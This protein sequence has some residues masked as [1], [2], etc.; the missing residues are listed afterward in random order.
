MNTLSGNPPDGS[1]STRSKEHLVFR[2][3]TSSLCCW[4]AVSRHTVSGTL[5]LGVS[6]RAASAKLGSIARTTATVALP[7]CLCIVSRKYF[8]AHAVRKRHVPTSLVTL[9]CC[10]RRKTVAKVLT[11]AHES[12]F[13][14]KHFLSKTRTKNK[15]TKRRKKKKKNEQAT[16]SPAQTFPT[17]H[18]LT[19][20]PV[21]C[22]R[23]S[24]H[25][26]AT[27]VISGT[28][29]P[30]SPHHPLHCVAR[31]FFPTPH[32]LPR[33]RTIAYRERTRR[34]PDTIREYDGIGLSTRLPALAR[35]GFIRILL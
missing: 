2:M 25:D 1:V 15:T 6:L 4:L 14:S 8:A 28:T 31:R 27:I 33:H 22:S 23:H 13:D 11:R 19:P 7:K 3:C 29:S 5:P 30:T 26:F 35:W 20:S 21:P 10:R 12:A 18:S 34:Q 9:V 16:R 17:Q 24:R 32:I